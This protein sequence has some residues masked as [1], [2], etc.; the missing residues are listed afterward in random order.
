MKILDYQDNSALETC[1]LPVQVVHRSNEFGFPVD[2][3]YSV[4][5]NYNEKNSIHEMAY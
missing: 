3:T 4:N 5:I 2:S 1:L